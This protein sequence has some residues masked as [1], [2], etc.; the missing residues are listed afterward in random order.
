MSEKTQKERGKEEKSTT[1][2][3]LLWKL[4]RAKIFT[5]ET[6][7]LFEI[8]INVLYQI[9]AQARSFTMLIKKSIL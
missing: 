2:I 3:R 1:F 6:T 7:Y 9:H 5:I 8:Q 4:Q